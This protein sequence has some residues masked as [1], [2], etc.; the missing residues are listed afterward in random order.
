MLPTS[1]GVVILDTIYP[2]FV[3]C[4]GH[5]IDVYHFTPGGGIV[6]AI[7]YCRF[8]TH[9]VCGIADIFLSVVQAIFCHGAWGGL[10]SNV[11]WS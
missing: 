7:C 10:G 1:L 5:E 4:D 9:G 3:Q 6:V 8:L 11:A 2:V